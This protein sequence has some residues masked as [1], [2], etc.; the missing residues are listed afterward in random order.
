[1]KEKGDVDFSLVDQLKPKADEAVV[2]QLRVLLGMAE[3]GE[4]KNIFVVGEIRGEDPL[5][6]Q[7]GE[8]DSVKM[9]G[10]LDWAKSRWREDEITTWHDG[11]HLLDP[12]DEDEN[13][14][15]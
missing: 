10:I 13:G 2:A 7:A 1:M 6:V 3:I 11:E 9:L 14:P 8:C 15:A 4:L 5:M 12:E